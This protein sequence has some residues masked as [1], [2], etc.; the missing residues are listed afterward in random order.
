MLHMALVRSPYANARIAA[1]DNSRG[2][3][4]PGVL[5]SSPAGKSW[6]DRPI[7]T[8]ADVS[9]LPFRSDARLGHRKVRNAGDGGGG[10]RRDHRESPRTPPAVVVDYEPLAPITTTRPLPPGTPHSSMTVSDPT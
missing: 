3:P 7:F 6:D 1:V 5:G 8:L 4:G 2:W 9:D 10:G